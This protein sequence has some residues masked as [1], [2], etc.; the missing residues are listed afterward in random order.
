VRRLRSRS[1]APTELEVTVHPGWA[2][3]HGPA[4]ARL[5]RHQAAGLSP[6]RLRSDSGDDGRESWL[7][8]LGAVA[9]GEELLMARSVWRR[10]E[11]RVTGRQG[12]RF[13]TVLDT[14]KPRRRPVPTPLQR[15]GGGHHSPQVLGSG[16]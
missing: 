12:W 3:L 7:S 16:R 6:L 14:F 9:E 15:G 4:L 2:H 8:R 5:V 10:Q 13:D 1:L 11:S